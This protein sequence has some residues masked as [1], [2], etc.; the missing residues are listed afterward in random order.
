MSVAAENG[1]VETGSGANTA[2][3]VVNATRKAVE[4]MSPLEEKASEE[5]SAAA[6]PEGAEKNGERKPEVAGMAT[7]EDVSAIVPEG[8]TV[9]GGE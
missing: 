7:K 3:D 1:K 2:T 5:S 9:K 4:G 6:E 8:A